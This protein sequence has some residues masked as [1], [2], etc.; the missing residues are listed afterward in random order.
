[1][2]NILKQITEQI[3]S[4][5]EMPGFLEV[6]FGKHKQEALQGTS[7]VLFGA[8]GLGEELCSTL[9]SH[10]VY[11]VC[12]CDNNDSREGDI[13]CGIPVIS[14]R[15]LKESYRE[16][17]IVIAS[18]KYIS[19]LTN[20]LLRN[21]FR[22]DRV[23]CKSSDACAPIVF[24]YS[25]IGTRCLFGG[26]KKQCEPGTVLDVLL[27]HES[28]L[29]DAYNL[30]VDRHSKELFISKL[31]LMAS[32]DN[33]ELFSNFIRSFSQPILEFGFGNYDGT[34]EDY[35]YFNND[36]LSIS[37]DE[38]YV[39]VGAYDGDTVLTFIDACRRNRMDYKWIHAFEPDPQCYNALVQNTAGYVNISCQQRGVWSKSQT[40]RFKSSENGIHDQAGAIDHS[41]NIEIDVV[42]L[43]DYLRGEKV[44]FIK[45]DPG[46]NV[47]PQAIQ[48][49]ASTIARHRPKLALG[50]YHAV[51]SMFEI[52][53][54]VHQICPDYKLS[55]RH[56]TYH[57][58][59]TDLYATP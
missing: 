6:L 57:L 47:I 33:F 55:L 39:D 59:D 4:T 48:G 58:C 25:M 31:A 30:L 23:L 24:M 12:F 22:P 34:P 3:D 49:A 14:F 52:P 13:Y 1:M 41:G 11:P 8:G 27:H 45:M 32:E 19:P 35:F 36:V 43:D 18:H 17:L 29:S 42:S 28:P 16:N 54:L 46:G 40:L 9:R 5:R 51:E 44:S 2:N 50:A 38:V 10:G 56:N 26:Y 53:L 37:P 20:Q 7:V 15:Q 21:G